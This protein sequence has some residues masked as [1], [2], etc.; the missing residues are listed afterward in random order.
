MH[1]FDVDFGYWLLSSW[2]D[3]RV[4]IASLRPIAVSE[5]LAGYN[6]ILKTAVIPIIIQSLTPL[7]N[8]RN[9]LSFFLRQKK[10]REGIVAFNGVP[11]R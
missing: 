9:N 5:A 8:T 11:K 7:I 1:Y 10:K 3:L 4:G 2:A 6:G